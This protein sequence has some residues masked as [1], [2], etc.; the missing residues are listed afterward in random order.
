MI[1]GEFEQGIAP[2]IVESN[3]ISESQP[4]P[5]VI[6]TV[7]EEQELTPI[8]T[9]LQKIIPT[10]PYPPSISPEPVEITEP[11]PTSDCKSLEMTDFEIQ[12]YAMDVFFEKRQV[13]E[14]IIQ[15]VVAL[16]ET[17]K[18]VVADLT[19][20]SD[21]SVNLN[22]KLRV[23]KILQET[24]M[25]E[26]VEEHGTPAQKAERDV[27]AFIW[28]FRE[29]LRKFR[30]VIIIGVIIVVIM[31]IFMVYNY[32]KSYGQAKAFSKMGN[33]PVIKMLK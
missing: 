29:F 17:Q 18:Q 25:R 30:I 9:I 33:I 2:K 22:E 3:V 28:K 11:V 27:N 8:Q 4:E 19:T 1:V 6:S 26:F 14:T 32:L 5:V 20:N 13:G 12:L 31:I 23:L 16:M 15:F 7:S 21:G 24:D 10:L